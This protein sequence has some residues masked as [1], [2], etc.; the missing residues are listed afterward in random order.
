MFKKDNGF[1]LLMV[2]LILQLLSAFSFYAYLQSATEL[3]QN[4]Y[5]WQRENAYQQANQIFLKVEKLINE[6]TQCRISIRPASSFIKQTKAWWQINACYVTSDNL[7]YFYIIESLGRDDCAIISTTQ[8]A[9][10]YRITLNLLIDDR[11]RLLLQRTVILPTDT[12]NLCASKQH[13]V[14]IGSQMQREI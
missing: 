9:D 4:S 5:R 11:M 8:V 14:T 1:V 12:F 3:K 6:T 7:N 13:N 10:Y 2:L